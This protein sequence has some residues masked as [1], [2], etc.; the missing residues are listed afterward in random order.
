MQPGDRV[1]LLD[2][3][4]GMYPVWT[5]IFKGE[6]VT[7]AYDETLEIDLDR[8]VAALG[9][10]IRLLAIANPDQPTGHVLTPAQLDRLILATREAG[11]LCLIDEAYY[12]FHPETAAGVVGRFDHLVVLRTFSKIGGI[13]GLRV[14]YAMANPRIIHALAAVRS[15][16]EVNAV[17][18]VIAEY[19]L[20]HPQIMTD[21]AAAVE[22]GRAL[23]IEAAGR[24]GCTAPPCAGNFQLLRLPTGLDAGRVTGGLRERGYLIKG[25]FTAA[26]LKDC[27]R[28]TLDGPPVIAPFVEA[29][30][31]T[32]RALAARAS[33]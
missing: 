31:A 15:P 29:L 19:L 10:G 27:I 17:G 28:V 4:Y 3:S 8:V 18:A 5:R 26:G 20:D 30:T 22:A 32:C 9:T 21:F 11:V 12:P 13:A 24:L 25:G 1:L 33:D 16:G 23:L 7:V 14:G 2:P 6:G